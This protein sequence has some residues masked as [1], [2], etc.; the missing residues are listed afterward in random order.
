MYRVIK[1][2]AIISNNEEAHMIEIEDIDN[3]LKNRDD[4]SDVVNIFQKGDKFNLEL[5]N[6]NKLIDELLKNKYIEPINN[7]L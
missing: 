2:F 4:F 3:T 1:D 7:E 5:Y 6:N